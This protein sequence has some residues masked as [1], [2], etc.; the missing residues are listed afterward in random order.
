MCG[1][2]ASKGGFE[3]GD[4]HCLKPGLVA[5]SAAETI[6]T[7]DSQTELGG[8]DADDDND[9]FA[10]DVEVNVEEDEAVIEDESAISTL[11]SHL[12]VLISCN[13]VLRRNLPG[14]L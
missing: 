10:S 9:P 6:A 1:I 12:C 2:T 13:S 8:V 4:I 3:D 5:T 11:A 14:D 7:R